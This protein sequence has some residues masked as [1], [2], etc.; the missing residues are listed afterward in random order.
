MDART[1]RS[2]FPL[3]PQNPAEMEDFS[4]LKTL[5]EL[6]ELMKRC[7]ACR[8]T[9]LVQSEI[10][11]MEFLVKMGLLVGEK[12]GWMLWLMLAVLATAMTPSE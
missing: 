4:P 12:L 3:V 7:K 5:P 10:S 9:P 1:L 11:C 6:G 8:L 2:N